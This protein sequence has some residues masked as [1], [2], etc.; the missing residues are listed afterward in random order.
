MPQYAV[1]GTHPANGCPMNSKGARESA[2]R[3]YDSI[4]K[5]GG[6]KRV[7][8]VLN[9]HLDPAHKA[10]MLFEAPTA[11]SVRDCLMEC[12]FA[13]FLDMDFHLVT[14]ISELLKSTSDLPTIYP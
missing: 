14:P 4:E 2:L 12:G 3:A 11:E 5:E 6:K 7:K 1:I 9:I 8:L 10:F 13:G